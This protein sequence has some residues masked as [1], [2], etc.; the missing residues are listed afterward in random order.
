MD[1]SEKIKYIS[2]K[3][4]EFQEAKDSHKNYSS[5][6]GVYLYTTSPRDVNDLLT[7]ENVEE[8]VS[9]LT[10]QLVNLFEEHMD[11]ITK[12]VADVQIFKSTRLQEI[13]LSSSTSESESDSEF[14][15]YVLQIHPQEEL[16]IKKRDF[17]QKITDIGKKVQAFRKAVD[18]HKRSAQAAVE[19]SER[20]F[21]ELIRS[22]QKRRT[23]VREL[24]RAQE[25]RETGQIN[26][27]IQKLEQEISNLQKENDKL[28][29]ILHTEDYIHFFQ[30]YSSQSGVYLYTT[31]PRDV[32]D[33]L[34]FE[35]VEESV[36]ALNSQ[37][38]K[39]CKEHMDKISKKVADVQIFK[40]TRLQDMDSPVASASYLSSDDDISP[41][42]PESDEWCSE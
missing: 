23:E 2:R 22:I 3:V 37:L 41:D 21:N 19:H 26:E 29:P 10:N 16:K 24:I 25:K 39:L 1:F 6:S 18:S 34:T 20:I 15:S 30:N 38:V 31:S 28:G 13:D 27:H 12:K 11:K 32:N 40:T 33:L 36:S 17:T 35:N 14:H 5:Q 9:E 8:S 42:S 7:F 4:K